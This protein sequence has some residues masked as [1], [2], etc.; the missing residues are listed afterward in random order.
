MATLAGMPRTYNEI[1]MTSGLRADTALIISEEW[2]QHLRIS[3]EGGPNSCPI[4]LPHRNNTAT[5]FTTP[6][7]NIATTTFQAPRERCLFILLY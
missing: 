4:S 2:R 3:I 5:L 7:A 6:P 1:D